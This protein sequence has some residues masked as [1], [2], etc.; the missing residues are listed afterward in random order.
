MWAELV[1]LQFTEYLRYQLNL[2][3]LADGLGDILGYHL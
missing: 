2:L 1:F 3:L